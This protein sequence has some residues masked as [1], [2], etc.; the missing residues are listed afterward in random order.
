MRTLILMLVLSLSVPAQ[1]FDFGNF[2]LEKAVKTVQKIK[3]ANEDV[4]EPQE[5]ELGGGIASNLLGAAPLLDNPEVQRY[6]NRIGRWIA[7]QTERPDIPWTFGVLDDPD[8]NAFAAPGGYVFITKGLLARMNNEAELAGVLAHEISHV[9]RKH[10]L[11]ALKKGARSELFSDLAND[12]IKTHGGDPRLTKLVS[13]GTEIYARGLDKQDEFES[14]RMGVVLAARA[15]YDPYGLP[16]VLQ[17]LQSINPGDSNLALMFKTHPSF[18]KRLALLSDEMTPALDAY[19]R[20]P[21][22]DVRFAGVLGAKR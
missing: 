21:A 4:S 14:D 10:H 15:G 22:L 6:V 7:L 18:D 8:I 1:A 16:A 13:A 20:Q 2:D 9:L 11:M 3:K 17:T 19:E 12:A 5:I